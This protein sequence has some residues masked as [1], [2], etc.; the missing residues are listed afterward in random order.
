MAALILTYHAIEPG[1]GPL[2][3][4]P[5]TFASHLDCIVESGAE[6]VTVSRLADALRDGTLTGRTVAITFDDGIAS[7]ARVAAPLLAE[8]SLTATVFCVAGHLGGRSNWA[9]ARPGAPVLELAGAEE[10]VQLARQGLEI[11]CHGMTHA[12]LVSGD[13]AFLRREL[14]DSKLLLGEAAQT[15]VTTL[16]YPYGTQ[17]GERARDAVRAS[18]EAACTT[19]AGSVGSGW[20]LFSLRRVDA[21]YVRHP[22]LLG[23]ALRHPRS[24]YVATRMLAAS[25]RRSVVRDHGRSRLGSPV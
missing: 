25:V 11:G 3:V 1:R 14:V 13:E 8:R 12:P 7:V 24:P 6:A 17:P 2:F 18:Y 20:D 15:R 5:D 4:D 9:S 21:H 19:R 23:H 16:A 22:A 10:L